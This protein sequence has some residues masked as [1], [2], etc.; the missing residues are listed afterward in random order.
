[1]AQHHHQCR[2]YFACANSLYVLWQSMTL[3]NLFILQLQ[4][5]VDFPCFFLKSQPCQA[6]GDSEDLLFGESK[7]PRAGT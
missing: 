5:W 6:S 2:I 4:N 3:Y 7:W 1:M